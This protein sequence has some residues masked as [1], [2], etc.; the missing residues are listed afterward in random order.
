MYLIGENPVLSDPDANH[1]AKA[2]GELEFFVVQDMFLTETAQLADVVLPAA[3][4]AE[5]DG[6]FTNSER[7]V[8]RVRRAVLPAGKSLPDWQIVCRVAQEMG[9]GGSISP[10]PNR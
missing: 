1:I 5:K 9:A 7:R 8:Q 3:S 6:T 10:Y 2:I 4:F